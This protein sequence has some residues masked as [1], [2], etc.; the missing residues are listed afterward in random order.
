MPSLRTLQYSW[1]TF[2][3]VV[4]VSVQYKQTCSV[5]AAA[6]LNSKLIKA[7]CQRVKDKKEGGGVK[8]A[9][10]TNVIQYAAYAMRDQEAKTLV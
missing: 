1:Y 4:L 2:K 10:L 9:V 3:L 5:Y 8:V 6:K 7:C